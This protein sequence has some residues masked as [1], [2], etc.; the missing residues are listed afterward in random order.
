MYGA[1]KLLL[2]VVLD[3]GDIFA[4]PNVRRRGSDNGK[5]YVAPAA[6]LATLYLL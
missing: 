1:L 4:I 3:G 2:L 6:Y 5:L